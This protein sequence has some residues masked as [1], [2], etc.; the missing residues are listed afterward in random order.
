[1]CRMKIAART[2]SSIKNINRSTT[3][4]KIAR[5]QSR[6]QIQDKGKKKKVPKDQN[7]IISIIKK[8]NVGKI[9]VGLPI[10]LKGNHS[11]QTKNGRIFFY[12][13]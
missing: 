6:D 8:H 9:L 5:L 11:E 4:E 1:M 10:T 3:V 7:K 13:F 12:I 2:G